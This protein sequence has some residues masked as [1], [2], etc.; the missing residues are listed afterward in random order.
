MAILRVYESR[1]GLQK[2]CSVVTSRPTQKTRLA[3]AHRGLL[4]CAAAFHTSTCLLIR[5]L[6]GPFSFLI[7]ARLGVRGGGAREGGG[8]EAASR[9]S[10]HVASIEVGRRTTRA[11]R[12]T[13][14]VTRWT[15]HFPSHP[16]LSRRI[17]V[18][19]I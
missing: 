8:K 6:A 9:G 17:R 18:K 2:L 7:E 11:E 5:L 10:P 14:G 15:H 12:T 13:D 4:T 3:R 1:I 16:R 19:H